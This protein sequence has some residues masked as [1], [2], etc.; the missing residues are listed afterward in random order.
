MKYLDENGL[1]Y[2]WGKI[3]TAL[4]TKVDKVDGKGLSSNDYTSDEKIKLSGIDEG[5]NNIT[6][7]SSLS[8]TSTNPVQNKVIYSALGNKVDKVSGK[9]LSTND[10]TT[11]EKTKLSNLENYSLPTASSSTLG[12]VKVGAGLAISNG[13]L[14]AT[15]GGTA[16][17]V[18]WSNVT[19]KPT[20]VS[21]FTNDAKYQTE[22]QV[23]TTVTNAINAVLDGAPEALNTLKELS[24]A[25]GDDADFANTITTALG[26]KL[27]SADLVAITNAEIDIIAV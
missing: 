11:E 18:D 14:S 5:A 10:Y 27:N 26:N 22:T 13:V 1:L 6:V 20:N 24:T 21:S 19:N 2:F 17:A 9:G 3:K 23:S 16:D 4:G 7:D 12:G 15:G 8:S 25:L